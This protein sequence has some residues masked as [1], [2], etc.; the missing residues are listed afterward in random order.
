MSAEEEALE[1]R[2]GLS[3]M[4]GVESDK[5]WEDDIEPMDLSTER[6]DEME[7]ED[8]QPISNQSLEESK[9]ME[10]LAGM[11]VQNEPVAEPV[12]VMPEEAPPLPKEGLPNGWT[13]E[14]WKW[15]GEEWLA[16]MGK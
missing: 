16:K 15:Y 14:Q 9:S 13:M 11:P 1:N 6:V 7:L 10:E 8:V 5:M 3:A 2:A 12:P 4:G